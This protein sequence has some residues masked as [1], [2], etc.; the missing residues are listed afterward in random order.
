M[1][2]ARRAVLFAA[3]LALAQQTP[4]FASPDRIALQREYR[5]VRLIALAETPGTRF[6]ASLLPAEDGL[7]NIAGALDHLIRNSPFSAKEFVRLK[8]S[9]QVTLVYKPGDLKNAHGGENVATFMPDYALEAGKPKREKDFLVIVGRH[10]V[11]WP[12]HEL[13]ATLAHELVGHAA[14]QRRDRLASI[15]HVDAECEAS[16]FEEI[17]N[18]DLGFKKHSRK[19]VVFRKTLEYRWCADFKAYMAA[20]VPGQMVQWDTLNPDMPKLLAVFEDYLAYSARIGVTAKSIN[21]LKRQTREQHRSMM[22]GASPEKI[23]RTALKLRNGAIGV[24]PDPAE[25]ARYLRLAAEN[26]L[27]SA[28]LDVA[29][30]HETRTGR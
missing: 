1:R 7:R 6:D 15:R 12:A 20:H 19:M 9:G 13:A 24:R 28:W 8:K 21:A 26:G 22:A 27:G 18:Q 17:A 11:K 29:P 10:G 30:I 16:M 4:A 23:F 2:P 14:Q 3:A 25:A 5:G